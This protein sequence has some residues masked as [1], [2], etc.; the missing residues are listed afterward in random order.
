VSVLFLFFPLV[1]TFEEG[2]GSEF[3][4]ILFGL[5]MTGMIALNHGQLMLSWNSL[6]FDLLLSRGNTI[7][8]IFTAKYYILVLS[9]II[10]YVLTL[11]YLFLDPKIVAFNTALVF[12][13]TS[14]SIYSYMVLASYNSMR[15]DPNEGGAL[16]MSGFGAAHYL[17]GIPIMIFP[18]VIYF[19]G[20]AAFGTTGGVMALLIVGVVGTLFHRRVITACVNLFQA[21]RYKIAAAFRKE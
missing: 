9:C 2:G 14:F 16:N 18:F 3:Y 4:Y 5:F 20:K 6:H 11:P 17:I 15:I 19:I 10:T 7:H 12:I 1:L 13:N 8:D 21:N